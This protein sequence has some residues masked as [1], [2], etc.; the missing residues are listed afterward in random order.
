M[1]DGRLKLVIADITTL[2]VDAIVCAANEAL[3]GGSG[4]DGAI[5]RAAGPGLFEECRQLGYG[6][7]GEARLTKGYLLPTRFVIH[8]AAG[9]HRLV[10]R[11]RLT[12]GAFVA[13]RKLKATL[14]IFSN[15]GSQG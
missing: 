8:T 11:R 12:D 15:C 6:P 1:L 10:G 13:S 7:E 3:I 14:P 5:H 9:A 2:A 4:V